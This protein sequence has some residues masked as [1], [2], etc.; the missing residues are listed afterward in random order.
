MMQPTFLNAVIALVLI[1]GA[2]IGLARIARRFGLTRV[3]PQR[4]APEGA[5]Q[6]TSC[7]IDRAR[8]LSIVELDGRQFAVLTGGRNDQLVLLPA[9]GR[10]EVA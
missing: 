7:R 8:N 4:W 10:G 5:R 6:R 1:L 3:V 9:M 2:I